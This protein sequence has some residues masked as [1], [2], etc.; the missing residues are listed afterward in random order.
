MDL[1]RRLTAAL[2][3]VAAAAVVVAAPVGSAESAQPRNPREALVRFVEAAGDADARGMWSELSTPTRR[4]LGPSFAR[5]RAGPAHE[6]HDGV[7]SYSRRSYVVILDERVTTAFAVAAIAGRR[8]V[9]GRAEHGVY[10]VALRLERGAWRL[11]LAA[12]IRIRAIR[13]VPGEA[14]RRRTQLAADVAAH[15]SIVEAG[16]WFD[17]RAFA[18]RGGATDPRHLGMFGEAPQPL[19]RGVHGVVAFA[20]AGGTATALGWAFSVR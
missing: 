18:A 15:A 6:L 5:F 20:A 17:G 2:G 3:L 7:G 14:V 9:E 10:A 19:R 12:P 1:R 16:M 13:P 8:T 11:E 4:R